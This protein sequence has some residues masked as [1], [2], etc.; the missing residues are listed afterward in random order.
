MNTEP[1]TGTP[2]R[3]WLSGLLLVAMVF[4]SFWSS[5]DNGWIWDDND[6]VTGNEILTE[7]GGLGRMWRERDSLPQWYPLVHT[8]FRWEVQN[9]GSDDDGNLIPSAFHLGNVI[10][11]ALC[12]LVMWRLLLRIGI[13]GAW[14]LAALWALHP[15]NVE[16]VAWVTERKNVLSML[17]ALGSAHAFFG[18]FERRN[19]ISLVACLLLF[20]G[21][22]LS[23]TVVASLPAVIALVL[24]W[25][26]GQ[27]QLRDW[28]P[29][30]LMLAVGSWMGWQTAVDEI[31]HVGAEGQQWDF[32]FVERTLVAGRILWFYA[33]KLLWP[34]PLVFIYERWEIDSLSIAQ[35]V[36]P[37]AA[38]LLV[39]GCAWLWRAKKMRGPLTAVL[40]YGGVLFP[41]LGYLNVYPHQYSFVADHFQHHATPALLILFGTALVRMKLPTVAWGVLLAVLGA[42]SF[43][44]GHVYENEETLWLDVAA[45]TPGAS[46]A[47][48]NLAIIYHQRGELEEAKEEFRLAIKYDP[49]N[50]Q[51]MNNLGQLLLHA[52][53][54]EDARELLEHAIEVQPIYVKPYVNMGDYW[55]IRAQQERKTAFA[56]KAIEYYEQANERNQEGW[57]PQVSL[58]A[59]R[60]H[61]A[62]GNANGTIRHL[63]YAMRGLSTRMDATIQMMWML[64]THPKAEIRD[65]KRALQLGDSLRGHADHAQ[66]YDALAAVLAENGKFD[67]AIRVAQRA[68]FRA[69]E[70]NQDSLSGQIRARLDKYKQGVAVRTKA[71]LP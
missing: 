65:G 53:K 7:E 22:L 9:W 12:A 52:G 68:A 49:L 25:R 14:F 61:A 30:A 59:A 6:Y 70:S 29:L 19:V 32:G 10:L 58:T 15:I 16:S 37:I 54:L 67:E 50:V 36:F 31:R 41:A 2:H 71:G 34:Y 33:G 45:K 13:G 48:N 1:I 47:P 26:H 63:E 35:W 11:H 69:M 17:M 5:I 62:L 21:A 20:V 44:Q 23:K 4:V 24:W 27:L 64:S 55:R 60:L 57:I 39:L 28:L 51:A 3:Q 18:W 43:Q 38:V 40:I 8:T 56:L 66:F 46:I 42:L